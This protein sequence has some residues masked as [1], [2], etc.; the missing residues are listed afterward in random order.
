MPG[1][2][3]IVAADAQIA[4]DDSPI[5]DKMTIFR[6]LIP[7]STSFKRRN[8]KNQAHPA[9]W[10]RLV[11]ASGHFHVRIHIEYD[12][13]FPDADILLSNIHITF[14]FNATVDR[15]FTEVRVVKRE[16]GRIR[17]RVAVAERGD[18]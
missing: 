11:E 5:D 4:V 16:V 10:A 7:I 8:G 9:G 12:Q 14:S 18:H 1:W 17:D 13:K 6:K 3:V 2:G 15:T